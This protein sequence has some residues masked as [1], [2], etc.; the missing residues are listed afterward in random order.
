[1]ECVSILFQFWERKLEIISIPWFIGILG[2][3]LTTSRE[4]KVFRPLCEKVRFFRLLIKAIEFWRLV[5]TNGISWLRIRVTNQ[6]TF[7]VG[8]LILDAMGLSGYL[9]S[10]FLSLWSLFLTLKF[11]GW[12]PLAR[13][14]SRCGLEYIRLQVLRMIALAWFS[15]F[16]MALVSTFW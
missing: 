15:I 3:K 5:R 11:A 2:Y 14:F 8:V 12:L 10:S 16:V 4:M 13:S 9:W 6:S 7:I 1:M